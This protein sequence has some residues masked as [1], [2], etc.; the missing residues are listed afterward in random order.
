MKLAIIGSRSFDNYF[1]LCKE[2]ESL[3]LY[4]LITKIVS[5]GSKGADYLGA[6]YALDHGLSLT[7]YYPEWDKYGKRAGFIRNKT[8]IQNSDIVI[9]F[10]DGESK[11]TLN[12][13]ELAKKYKKE[14]HI[15]KYNE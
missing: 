6:L 7:E 1:L 4:S 14:C 2:V 11:G 5:G 10:H 9:A 12:S 3:P 8:I 15:I 13:I